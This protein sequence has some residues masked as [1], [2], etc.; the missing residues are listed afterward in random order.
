MEPPLPIIAL[1]KIRSEMR[2]AALFTPQCRASDEWRDGPQI[3]SPPRVGIG[4]SVLKE[5]A[6]LVLVRRIKRRHGVRE[7]LTR[8]EQ[9]DRPP[10]QIPHSCG[11]QWLAAGAERATGHR[12]TVTGHLPVRPQ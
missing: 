6:A 7:A 8:P 5:P 12:P 9:A 11:I 1:G 4:R 3:E 10:H 2:A